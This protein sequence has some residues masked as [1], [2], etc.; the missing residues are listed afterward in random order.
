MRCQVPGGEGAAHK[1]VYSTATCSWGRLHV[2]ASANP[3][4]QFV[5]PPKPHAG[6]PYYQRGDLL[7][8]KYEVQELLGTRGNAVTY[9]VRG[10]HAG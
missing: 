1:A 7:A 5:Q 4:Q 9:K 8:G 3:I 6:Q 10:L 2:G